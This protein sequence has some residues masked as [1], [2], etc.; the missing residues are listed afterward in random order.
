MNPATFIIAAIFGAFLFPLT[1]AAFVA[2]LLGMITRE[3]I[4]LI[5][6]L[7]TKD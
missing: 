6:E 4:V 3:I 2:V 5:A 1:V 7:L